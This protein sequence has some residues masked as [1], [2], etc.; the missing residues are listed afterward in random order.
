MALAPSFIQTRILY[1]ADSHL[2][3][4]YLS[5]ILII[6]LFRRG[7]KSIRLCAHCLS[8]CLKREMQQK[9]QKSTPCSIKQNTLKKFSRIY[10][11]YLFV[12]YIHSFKTRNENPKWNEKQKKYSLH[13]SRNRKGTV[14]SYVISYMEVCPACIT[15]PMAAQ[16]EFKVRMRSKIVVQCRLDNELNWIELNL[17][18][19]HHCCEGSDW[20]AV[21]REWDGRVRCELGERGLGRV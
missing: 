16:G 5:L 13:V 1:H 15:S 4:E 21:R 20:V 6:D 18:D 12:Y 10:L 3:W 14:L 9:N 17:Y 11:L 8:I 7:T 2:A 19:E